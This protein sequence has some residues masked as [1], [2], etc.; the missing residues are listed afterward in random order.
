MRM[1]GWNAHSPFTQLMS[2]CDMT[3][4][5]VTKWTKKDSTISA[6]TP[7]MSNEPISTPLTPRFT[8]LSPLTPRSTTIYTTYNSCTTYTTIYNNL[9]HLHHL[10]H[11]S[12]EC[13]VNIDSLDIIGECGESGEC[14]VSGESSVKWCK[15]RFVGHNSH[16][17]AARENEKNGVKVKGNQYKLK[18][19]MDIAIGQMMMFQSECFMDATSHLVIHTHQRNE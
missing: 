17:L 10:H 3:W 2:F 6:H 5:Q 13:G 11:K 12:G 19:T 18:R 15:Y 14:G 1:N 8:T 4:S 7:Y 16:T 9:H